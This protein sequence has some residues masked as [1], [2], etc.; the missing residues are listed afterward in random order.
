MLCKLLAQFSR[1]QFNAGLRPEIGHQAGV[2][3]HV[4]AGNDNR[5]FYPRILNELGFD[6]PQLNAEAAQLDLK[7]V[8]AEVFDIAIRQPAAEIAGFIQ[9]GTRY[10]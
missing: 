4:F 5:F 1:Y 3:R 9:P 7:I 6:F 10:G 8:T 2:A